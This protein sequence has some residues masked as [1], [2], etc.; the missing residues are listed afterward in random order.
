MTAVLDDVTPIDETIGRRPPITVRRQL[1]ISVA[2][3][4][5]VLAVAP[6][7]YVV[8]IAT[9]V[10]LYAVLASALN[11]VTGLAGLLDL[12][13]IAFFGVGAYTYALLASPLHGLNVSFWLVIPIGIAVSMA[14]GVIIA[15]PALRT[16]GDYLAIVTL[17]FG[18]IVYILLVNLDRPVNIT[19]GPQ[20]VL[21]I[22][23]PKVGSFTVGAGEVDLGPVVLTPTMQFYLLVC[24]YALVVLFCCLRL[25]SS[26]V[27]RAWRAMR[28]SEAA[29][30]AC[31]ISIVRAKL[32]AF[33]FGAGVAG[34]A[35]VFAAAWYGSIFPDSFLFSE[36]IRILSMVVLGGLGSVWGPAAGAFALVVIPELLREFEQ[37]RLL[38]FGMVLVLMMR[39]RPQGLLASDSLRTGRAGGAPLLRRVL[40]RRSRR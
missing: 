10:V 39:F 15:I 18:E 25:P 40:A 35:G 34:G 1:G 28:E 29:A 30:T 23:P 32:S 7:D 24:L 21:G 14:L 38:V 3:L 5:L 37:Y 20:G 2:V 27:G 33:I 17:G 36:S 6:S 31:G 13:F 12:G 19:N 16:H 9:L 11:V 4:L 8:R 22:N 26:R